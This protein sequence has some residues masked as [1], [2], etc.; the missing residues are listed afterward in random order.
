MDLSVLDLRDNPLQNVKQYY[1]FLRSTVIL[2][3]NEQQGGK[4]LEKHLGKSKIYS[5]LQQAA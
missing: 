1:K 2:A 5:G 4:Q 3:W